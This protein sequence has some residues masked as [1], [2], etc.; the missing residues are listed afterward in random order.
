MALRRRRADAEPGAAGPA[1][2]VAVVG[3]FD[4][5][6]AASIEALRRRVDGDDAFEPHVTFAL[7]D[8]A[9]MEPLARRLEALAP[10]AAIALRF[11]VL[12]CFPT[13]GVL[14][15]APAASPAL[16]ALHAALHEPP[17][18]LS[19]PHFRPG[20]WTPHCTL[21]NG[22]DA[23]ALGAATAVLAADFPVVE[24]TLEALAIVDFPPP[25]L[26]RRFALGGT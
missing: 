4:R 26:R 19:L 7:Y 15:L 12:G 23:A 21:A 10:G 20:E 8:A 6:A 11:S 17:A 9:P 16:T 18:P 3:L 13:S 1:L 25:R 14:H 24:A 5:A 22:L 2:T